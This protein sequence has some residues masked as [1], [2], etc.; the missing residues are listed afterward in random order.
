MLAIIGYIFFPTL[1]LAI[2][3]GFYYTRA[4]ERRRAQRGE[5]CPDCGG[6]LTGYEDAYSC[7]HCFCDLHDD[8]D[9]Y[10]DGPWDEEEVDDDFDD[11]RPMS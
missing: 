10:D 3:V 2:V 6:D 8:E 7:P 11:S 5:V 9:D 4:V 1:V